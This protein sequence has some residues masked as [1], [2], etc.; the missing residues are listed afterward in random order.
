MEDTQPEIITP[1]PDEVIFDTFCQPTI[2]E[3]DYNNKKVLETGCGGSG[4]FTKFLLDNGAMVTVNDIREENIQHLF[5]RQRIY[6]P[7]NT[8]DL[9]Q[10][11]KA[12][13]KKE[14]DIIVSYGTLYHLHHFE[15]G[16][17]NLSLLCKEYAII[18][19]AVFHRYNNSI[20]LVNED[21]NSPNN[22]G[23]HRGCRPSREFFYNTLKKYFKYVYLSKTIPNH[24]DYPVRFFANRETCRCIFIGSHIMLDENS[25]I[26]ETIINNFVRVI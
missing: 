19:S 21:I 7:Y 24:P 25:N 9:N 2:V 18:S 1:H 23:T 6:L 20:N 12:E 11:I 3:F 13:Y 8:W 17:Q 10:I 22:I 14:F 26:T 16:I 4:E 15:N 5:K